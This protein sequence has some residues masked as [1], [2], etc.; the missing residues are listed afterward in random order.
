MATV[1]PGVMF[2]IDADESRAGEVVEFKPKFETSKFKV[3]LLETVKEDTGLIDITEARILVSGGRGLGNKEGFEALE[4]LAETL[5]AEVSASRAMVDS[6]YIGHERQV[7]QTGKTVRPNLYFAFG[8]SGA[9]QHVAGMEESELIV[10][11]NKDKDA[12]IFQVADLGIVGDAKQIIKKL[13]ERL[14]K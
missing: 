12:P 6:G 4:G 13:N 2:A 3:K 9:I 1:R 5:D 11:V 7:G 8:I 14:N 10:A